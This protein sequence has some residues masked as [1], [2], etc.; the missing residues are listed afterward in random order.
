MAEKDSFDPNRDSSL[1]EWNKSYAELEKD[2]EEAYLTV[3]KAIKMDEDG[4][5]NEVSLFY[6]MY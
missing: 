4:K 2:Y 5:I 6:W 1:K 3:A